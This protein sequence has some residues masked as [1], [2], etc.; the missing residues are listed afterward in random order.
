MQGSKTILAV[1]TVIALIIG[2]T[3]PIRPRASKR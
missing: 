2:T 1:A 3:T